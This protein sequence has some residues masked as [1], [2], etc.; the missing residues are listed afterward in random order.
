MNYCIHCGVTFS[1]A[2]PKRIYCEN[3]RCLSARQSIEYRKKYSEKKA[4]AI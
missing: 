4:R 1:A 3:Q 2:S